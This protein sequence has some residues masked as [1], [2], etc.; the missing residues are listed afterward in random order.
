MVNHEAN[1]QFSIYFCR[2]MVGLHKLPLRSSPNFSQHN[3]TLTQTLSFRSFGITSFC[4]LCT[5]FCRL[6]D[7]VNL[8]HSESSVLSP[9]RVY[10]AQAVPLCS[11]SLWIY[12][13]SNKHA[14]KLHCLRFRECIKTKSS[15]LTQ[16]NM[17]L[18][19]MLS[20]VLFLLFP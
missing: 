3:R 9:L 13:V 20:P 11:C 10:F 4:R 5:S 18:I 1:G 6:Q 16:P 8:G 14:S 7:K 15:S 17:L 12:F 19:G 2:E